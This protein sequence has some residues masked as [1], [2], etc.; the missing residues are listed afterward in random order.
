VE[1]RLGPQWHREAWSAGG[2][3]RAVGPVGTNQS[4]QEVLSAGAPEFT[5]GSNEVYS[6]ECVET[7]F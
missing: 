3:C 2:S 5:E 1:T 7:E 6:P 4:T